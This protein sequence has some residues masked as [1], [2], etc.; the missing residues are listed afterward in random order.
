MEIRGL[1]PELHKVLVVGCM[2]PMPPCTAVIKYRD[3]HGDVTEREVEPYEVKD[4]KLW[5]HCRK[6]GSLRQFKLTEIL[7]ARV[8][9]PFDPKPGVKIRVPT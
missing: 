4:G 1:R 3:A 6:A 5:A 7:E 9:Q 2:A 8:G